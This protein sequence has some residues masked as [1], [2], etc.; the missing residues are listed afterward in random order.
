MKLDIFLET[1]NY[2]S[3]L[4]VVPSW[5]DIKTIFNE[6]ASS[7]PFD[8]K[9]PI[10]ACEAVGGNMS[11]AI[12]AVASIAMLQASIILIDDMLDI[13]PRGYYHKVGMPATANLASA[14]QGLSLEAIHYGQNYS[15]EIKASSMHSL[16]SM[17][18][19]TALGQHWDTQ[20]M[21]GE[22]AYWRVV[23]TKSAP[24]FGTALYIGALLGG[25]SL[26]LASELRK[27]GCLYGEMIQIHD[28]LNDAMATPASP[29]WQLARLSLPI[30]FALDVPHPE[31]NAFA[32]L[33][34]DVNNPNS[35]RLAQ[36]ILIR[37][38][39]M[40][41]C[42]DQLL[43]RYQSVCKQLANIP[44]EKP[45]KIEGLLRNIIQPVQMLFQELG[46]PEIVSGYQDSSVSDED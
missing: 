28:D 11:H 43:T 17:M 41:Y 27:I 29:D 15:S 44:L 32:T 21:E 6:A 4:P 30:L 24:F 20:N 14:L 13:D 16:G 42:V 35:L 19:K 22:E 33:R 26:K 40:S 7:H 5:P 12:P 8:W 31:Q 1:I 23:R 36:E 38:G 2:V 37:S 18:A 9:L 45:E 10:L 25:A 34:K 46:L 39:A 3:T